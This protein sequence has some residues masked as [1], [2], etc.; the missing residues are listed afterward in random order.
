MTLCV[1][2]R[3]R[4]SSILVLILR[5]GSCSMSAIKRSWEE[6]LGI[7]ITD[8]D[9]GNV[10]RNIHSSSMCARLCLLQ[11]KIVHRVHLS[12]SKLAKMYPQIDPTCERCKL[13]EA[14]LIHMFWS[15]PK[16]QKFWTDVCGSLSCIFGIRVSLN[17]LLFLFGVNSDG[18]ALP[19][20]GQ[21]IIVFSTLLAR[22]LIL[23]KWK[24]AAPP[25]VSHW[26]RDV[27]FHLKLEKIRFVLRGSV[28]K[29]NKVWKPFLIFF[30]QPSTQVQE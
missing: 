17:P 30:D 14:T 16:I 8:A 25:K 23:L 21:R 13:A 2:T 1:L 6:D 18:L 5:L 12:K 15:C 22:R 10:L 4:S 24:D 28:N 7:C 29:F 26:V 3:L 11:F 20:G 19:A 9:W 27:L